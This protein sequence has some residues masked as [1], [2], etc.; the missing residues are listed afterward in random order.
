MKKMMDMI[1]KKWRGNAVADVLSAFM[2]AWEMQGPD[3]ISISSGTLDVVRAYLGDR[4]CCIWKKQGDGIL[5]IC[6]RGMMDLFFSEKDPEHQ[7]ALKR[8]MVTGSSEFDLCRLTPMVED[9]HMR[10]DGLLHIPIKSREDVMG[11]FSLAVTKKESRDRE[12]VQPLESLGRLVAIALNYSRDQEENLSRE[13]RLK[14]EVEATTHELSETN[15]RLIARVRELKTLY[16]ELQKR[17]EELT[18]A[19]RAKDEFLSIVSHELRTPLTSLSG[20]LSVL[21]DEEAGPISEQQR[22]FLG[23]AKQSAT[24]LNLII[25]DLLDVSRI[26]SGRLNLEMGECSLH[27]ILVT[28]HE[29]LKA[30]AANKS[31]QLRLHSLPTLPKIWGDPSRLQQVVDNIVSNAIKF[32]DR[33]GEIDISGEEKGDFLLISIRDTGPGLAPQEQE[34]VFDMFYQADASTRR[35]AGGA[36]LGLAI[37]RGIVNMHGGQIMVQSEKGKG[38]T[39]SF[40]IP[41]KR[42]QKKAA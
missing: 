14:A 25:S 26:E 36:G 23:I 33:G 39:F 35:S 18:N 16:A 17:V 10:F 1:G 24:R 20:F 19:N 4:A 34:K 22:K 2:Q 6:E 8:A 13:R 11:L 31:I 7:V 29:G 37:A 9:I 30:A 40:L 32:T 41:R 28:S 3:E 12:F 27:D 21:L 38:A 5:K 15:E 42:E